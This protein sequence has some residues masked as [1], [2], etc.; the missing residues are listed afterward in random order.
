MIR[1][2][3]AREREAARARHP[4]TLWCPDLDRMTR[5][6]TERRSQGR[7]DGGEAGGGAGAS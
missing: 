3:E 4:S 1:R 2:K 5:R 7:P 6:L